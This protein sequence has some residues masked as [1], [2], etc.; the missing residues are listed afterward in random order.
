ME[1]EECIAFIRSI[2]PN[3]ETIPLHAPKFSDHAKNEVMRCLETSFVSTMGQHTEDFEKELTKH[4][5]PY[6]AI[7]TVNGTVAIQIALEMIGVM[8]GDLVL[9]QALTFVG[10]ANAIKHVGADPIFIDVNHSTMGFDPTIADEF[11]KTQAVK[12]GNKTVH[13]KSGRKISALLPMHTFGHPVDIENLLRISNDWDLPIIEDAAEA[14]GSYYCNK[15]LGTF[16]EIGCL[17]FNGNKVIT[18]GGGGALLFKD[19]QQAAKA[20]HLIS[21]AKLKHQYKFLHDAVGY[22][23]RMPSLN[24]ALGL[25]Q[26]RDLDEIIVKKRKL[27]HQY[28]KFFINNRKIRFF[29]ENVNCQSNY[30]LNVLIF[31]NDIDPI[32]W[33]KHLNNEGINVR[34]AWELLCNLPMYEECYSS[35]LSNSLSLQKK[36]LCLPSSI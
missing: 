26:L 20:K 27:A 23:F 35:N 5:F 2:Y 10:T 3:E 4:F 34:P 17:S 9:T 19:N 8:P 24:A 28:K 13:K 16:G 12:I 25:A 36:I 14:L 31:D 21:T 6:T 15:P 22:N 18:T 33:T 32:K 1:I 30:W 29:E 7:L 11:L